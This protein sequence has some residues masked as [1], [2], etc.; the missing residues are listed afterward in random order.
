MEIITETLDNGRLV[1]NRDFFPLLERNRLLGAKGIWNL[2]DEGIKEVLAE[3]RTGRVILHASPEDTDNPKKVETY[4]KRYTRVPL[5]RRLKDMFS[6]KFF[7]FDALHEWQAQLVF[8]RLELPTVIPV[9]AGKVREGTFN[10][11]LG[12]ANYERASSLLGKLASADEGKKRLLIEKIGLYVGRMHRAGL[13]HQDLYLVHFFI[14]GSDMVPHLIDLQ[15][16][17]REKELSDRWRIKDLG[18]LLFSARRHI[19]DEDEKLFSRS[20]L[21]ASGFDLCRHPRLLRA[22]RKKA[23]W[24]QARHRRKMGQVNERS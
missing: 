14:K 4:I 7:Q 10:L 18:Q 19:T 2:R 23:D 21:Q 9:A 16:V 8:H 3:R 15:R 20:Y 6:L 12:I 1:I 17:I 13:A 11:T 5:S 24:I 22:I